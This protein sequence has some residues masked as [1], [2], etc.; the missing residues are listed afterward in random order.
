MKLSR[1]TLLAML[2]GSVFAIGLPQLWLNLA[3]Q[4][5]VLP[6]LLSS[7]FMGRPVTAVIM[8]VLGLFVL[9]LAIWRRSENP[10]GYFSFG[11]LLTL[12]GVS[13]DFFHNLAGQ[14]YFGALAVLY[15]LL[16]IL[17]RKNEGKDTTSSD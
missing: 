17:P 6:N 12:V 5:N 10:Y 14:F 9:A 13:F 3:A 11:V 16:F 1:K 4:S 7:S 15:I 8:V 2:A